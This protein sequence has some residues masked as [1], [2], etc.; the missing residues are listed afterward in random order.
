MNSTRVVYPVNRVWTEAEKNFVRANAG[1]MSDARL[2]DRLSLL[3]GRT[4][5]TNSVRHVRTRMGLTKK[6]G[7]GI[8]EVVGPA[9]VV[10]LSIRAD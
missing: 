10:G 4:V 8:C 7:R 3:T 6:S 2:A 9:R 5:T 1:V